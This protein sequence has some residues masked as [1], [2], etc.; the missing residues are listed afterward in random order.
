MVRVLVVIRGSS[1]KW[2]LG[3][4]FALRSAAEMNAFQNKYCNVARR[5]VAE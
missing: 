2:P 3:G 1:L 5:F 4:T